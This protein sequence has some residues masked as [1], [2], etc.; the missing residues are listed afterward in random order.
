MR[1]N[2]QYRLVFRWTD[3]NAHDVLITDHHS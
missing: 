2:D 1:V 3:G